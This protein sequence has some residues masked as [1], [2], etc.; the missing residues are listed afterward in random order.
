M[1][2]FTRIKSEDK[3]RIPGSRRH[4]KTSAERYRDAETGKIYTRRQ[5][6]KLAKSIPKTTRVHYRNKYELLRESYIAKQAQKGNKI[7][8]R[9]AGLGPTLTKI[10]KDLDKGARL[11]KQGKK[12]QGDTLIRRALQKTTRRDGIQRDIIPGESPK[13]GQSGED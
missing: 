13:A 10:I 4:I 1:A 2:V 6:D 11:R 3:V 9:Q 7:T 12:E 5:R 8:K